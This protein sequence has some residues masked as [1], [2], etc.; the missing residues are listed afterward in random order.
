[1]KKFLRKSLKILLWIL[2]GIITILLLLLLLI[3]IPAVQNF[4]KDE[5]VAFLENKIGT[6]VRVDNLEIG[7]PKKIILEGFYFEDQNRDTLAAGE[8]LAVN[9]NFYKLL[10]NT[11]EISSIELEGATA[12]ISRNRDSVFNFDYI[13][14]A[15]ATD[16]PQDTTAAMEISIGTINLDRVRFSWNDA[17]T[18]SVITANLN[19][20]DSRIGKFDPENL[21]YEIPELN[22]DGLRFQM[23]QGKVAQVSSPLQIEQNSEDSKPLDLSL[24]DISLKN[25]S[26]I[27]RSEE[28]GLDTNFELQKLIT[29]VTALQM[30][31]EYLEFD[32]L[33]L[34]GLNGALTIRQTTSEQTIQDTIAPAGGGNNWKAK[35][36]DIEI[37]NVAFNF[38]DENA[39]PVP[40]GVNF[41]DMELT[42]FNLKAGELYYSQD[43]IAGNINSATVRDKSG[44]EIK[45]LETSFLYSNNVSY[46]R[47]LNLETP[48]TLLRD[49][50]E[51][52][53]PSIASLEQDLGNVFI[54]ARL[55]ESYLGFQDVL[56]LAPDLRN[57]NPF[58]SNPN[59]VVNLNGRIEGKI[60]D[61]EIANFEASGIGN[62]NIA[63][64]G[65]IRGLP[66]V[67]NAYYNLNIRNFQ[68]TARDLDLFL[69]PGTIPDSITLP[70][71]FSATGNFRGTANNFDTRI[72]L[73]STS[74]NAIVDAKIDMRRANAEVYDANVQ[75]NDFD[76]GRLIQN[77]S[78]GSLTL[79]FKVDGT[80]FDPAT[81][82]ATAAGTIERAEYNSYVYRD[83]KFDGAMQNGDL[84]AEAEMLDP[85]LDFT[86][87]VTGN[88]QG[89]Y[90]SIFLNADLRNVALD[91]LNIYGS[92]LRFQGELVA[93]LDTADPDH[94]N[95]EIY[96]TNITVTNARQSFILDSISIR[97]IATAEVDSLIINSQFLNAVMYGDYNLTQIGPAVTN[98]ISKFYDLTPPGEIRVDTISPQQFVFEIDIR[99]DPI[100]NQLIEEF[101]FMEPIKISGSFNSATD[102]LAVNSFITRMRY[103]DY[104]ITNTSIDIGTT[105]EALEYALVIEDIDSPQIQLFHTELNGEARD[106]SISFNLEID[107][108]GGDLHYRVAGLME[109]EDLNNKFTLE[110]ENLILN[111]D[112]WSMP[113]DNSI[114]FTPTGVQATNFELRHQ[115]N[116]IRVN[117]K[118]EDPASPM[119]V[120]F[121]NFRIET[122]SAMISKDTL[123]AG[124]TINGDILLN[125]LTTSPQ[126]AADLRVENFNFKRDTVGNLNIKI[127]NETANSLDV[128]IVLSGAGNDVQF[129]GL[130]NTDTGNLD[131][132]LAMRQLNV[133][134]I[135][136]F[137]MGSLRDSEG[138]LS[139]DLRLE[140][141]MDEPVILGDLIFN[142]VGFI[143]TFLDNYFQN[144]NDR[145]TFTREGMTLNNFTVEDEDNNTLVMN[146]TLQTSDYLDYGFNL[147]VTADNFKAIS[148]TAEDNEFYYG[149]LILDTRLNIT[150]SLDNPV[151][152]GDLNIKEGTEITVVLPQEDPTLAD[153]E[154]V[155][156]FVDERSQRLKELREIEETVNSSAM[157]GM[158]VSVNVE[159]NEK[160]DFTLIIDEGNGDY[161][162]LR[163]KARLT[164]GI[165]PSGKT[166]LTGRYE[167]TQGAYEMSF[168]FIRRRFDIEPGSFI[169]WTGEPTTARIDIT[170]IYETE[171]APINLLGN[172]LAN[173][174]QGIQNTYKQEIPFQTILRM[175]GE[176]LTPELSFD[177]RLPE[178]NYGVSSEIVTASRAKLAQLRQQPSELNK[179]VFALLLLNRFIGEDPFSSAAG[180]T[181]AESLARQSVSKILSQQ[182]NDL[183]GDLI[184]GVQLEFDLESTDDYT[185]GQRE[186]RTDLNV[187]L[188]RT[189]LNDRLKVSI[190]S[191]FELEGPQGTNREANNI[192]GDIAVDYQ[193]SKDGRY[194]LRAYRKNQYQVALQG[195]IIETGVAFIITMDYNKFMEIFGRTPE[196]EE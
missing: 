10:S 5:A 146:G 120:E 19:H 178:G 138:Y 184:S 182:L 189:L 188:S 33:E 75:L 9:I 43:S 152:R 79:N 24:G 195:Q 22:V 175:Q 1:M 163:G 67:E 92:P 159:I 132:D 101:D 37:T 140:G 117:S 151:V 180:G 181:S 46:L 149:D 142:D 128:D 14:E 126:F 194:R 97:S 34:D 158:D 118:S 72:N 64:N 28:A 162:N 160:A 48:H 74:G 73:Q 90:P 95:G 183:A 137:S 93:D 196:T 161:L 44:L 62:T 27:L 91:S 170:A 116:A 56:L 29:T 21:I 125:D 49:Q 187:G 113:E 63:I 68:T 193:L 190:G 15:F 50:I 94:L 108:S 88:F 61:L 191:N 53:Y 127:D 156:E 96:L 87:N 141:T 60:N 4:I 38:K 164:A 103:L 52:R 122:I 150:G 106:N 110:I 66:D 39:P 71:R 169:N 176:L 35:L 135:Q 86:L 57:T 173:L 77:D 154:G 172:Q 84:K 112:K 133:K 104:R 144:M 107:D 85:N 136:G 168:N 165:D 115:N 13:T 134:S 20:L 3:Q 99:D 32:S 143:V 23:E 119:D 83:V 121:E 11:I 76:L 54:N 16:T 89:E 65:S 100:F 40:R 157:V 177:I 174:S 70:E 42:N 192:A 114:T 80:G 45:S 81:A 166:T 26:V 147:T 8:R 109:T 139:G 145:I 124:G 18:Q 171:T 12:N 185:T 129:A 69:P 41:M 25:V 98:T 179:Q 131:F 30:E 17:I 82:N 78:I 153:R 102:S 55:K 148:S 2:G 47:D 31:Q 51:A 6:P 123:L 186:Q 36:R 167:F 155:V 7:F 105:E 111:Y 130:Y 58:Q 59:A